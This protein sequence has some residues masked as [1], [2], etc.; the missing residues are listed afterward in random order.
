MT[1]EGLKS[2]S[3]FWYR[4]DPRGHVKRRF[5]AR[6]L[7]RT[8]RGLS[9]RRAKVLLHNLIIARRRGSPFVLKL[10]VRA[11][12]RMLV[13]A[14]GDARGGQPRAPG[15]SSAQRT[16]STHITTLHEGHILAICPNRDFGACVDRCLRGFLVI[17]HGRAG[18]DTG[19]PGWTA[20][21]PRLL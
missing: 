6:R 15:L 19:G 3:L 11:T 2:L 10:A 20:S 21:L 5:V 7:S 13:A 8:C 1:C 18:A 17:V 4:E 12:S 9:R 16:S 14:P